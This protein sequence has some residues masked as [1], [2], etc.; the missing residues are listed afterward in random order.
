MQVVFEAFAEIR[1]S[2]VREVRHYEAR[3][4]NG[5]LMPARDWAK[6]YY[7]AEIN[8][9]PCIL[10]FQERDGVT[11]DEGFKKGDRVKVSFGVVTVDSDVSQLSVVKIE[12][13]SVK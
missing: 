2:F 13:T 4:V 6:C 3:T 8:D 10:R 7:H 11:P 9:T 5:Q 1:S 12:K